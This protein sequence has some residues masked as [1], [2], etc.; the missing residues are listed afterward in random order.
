MEQFGLIAKFSRFPAD[1][2]YLVPA[3]LKRSPETLCAVDLS[4]SD[5]CPLYVYFN[6]GFVPHGLFSQL[7]SRTIR[8]SSEAGTTRS[9]QLYRNGACFVIGGQIL[10]FF[11]LICKKRFIKLVLKEIIESSH[12]ISV[13]KSSEVAPQVQQFV[14]VALE[15]LKQDLPYLR[16]LQYQFCVECPYCQRRKSKCEEHHQESCEDCSHFL[17]ISQRK[18]F[19]CTKTISDEE[20]KVPGMEKWFSQRSSQVNRL[21]TA[22]QNFYG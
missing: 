21:K 5:P 1:V 15:E 7:V 2:E 22:K 19:V 14:N 12:Q 16:G 6:C 3:Q 18:L 11:Y 9:P 4:Q 13:S 20:R 10:H 17:E 8:W